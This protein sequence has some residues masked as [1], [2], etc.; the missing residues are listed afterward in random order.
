[1]AL[2]WDGMPCAIC[3][4]P[5][6]DTSNEIFALTMWGITD[7]RFARLD[8]A[9]M[10]QSCIDNWH[11]RDEFIAFYNENCRDELRVNRRGNV[12]YRIDWFDLAANAGLLTVF[13]FLFAP[14]MPLADRIPDDSCL[15]QSLIGLALIGMLV[16]ATIVASNYLGVMLGVASVLGVWLSLGMISYVFMRHR[17]L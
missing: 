10:H 3:G 8:D 12:R 16:A 9:A 11:L 5:I 14:I 13:G 1:M 2:T 15:I 4:E 7:T 17:S 6:R